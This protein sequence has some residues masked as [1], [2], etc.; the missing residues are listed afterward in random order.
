MRT[1][2]V[3]AMAAAISVGP[4]AAVGGSAELATGRLVGQTQISFGCPGPVREGTPGC[5]PWRVFPHARFAV[6][7]VSAAGTQATT[8]RRVVTSDAQ[9]R[10]VVLLPT[11]SYV[12][13][14]LPAPRTRGGKPL[15]VKIA[16]GEVTTIRVRFAGFPLML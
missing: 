3:I 4:A 8:A 13:T 16:D 15:A 1:L 11:G 10:F 12:V 9:G 7:R 2:I 14:P 6:A 5:N